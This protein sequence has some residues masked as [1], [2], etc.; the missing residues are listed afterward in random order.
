MSVST[1]STT[2]PTTKGK[3]VDADENMVERETKHRM[4]AMGLK[5]DDLL[6]FSVFLH[7]VGALTFRGTSVLFRSSIPTIQQIMLK[8][9]YES[10]QNFAAGPA[11]VARRK[12]KGKTKI[13]RYSFRLT[14]EP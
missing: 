6:A 5:K 7:A 12:Y 8:S 2:I 1:F 14:N 11:G 3:E 9:C 13:V 4:Q 10:I